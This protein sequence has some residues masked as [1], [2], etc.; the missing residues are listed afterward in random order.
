MKCWNWIYSSCT[1]GLE[2]SLNVTLDTVGRRTGRCFTI[3]AEAWLF[4]QLKCQPV[5]ISPEFL[6]HLL[7]VKWNPTSVSTREL[8]I[9]VGG[10]ASLENALWHKSH[11]KITLP[12]PYELYLSWSWTKAYSHAFIRFPIPYVIMYSPSPPILY[13][14][15]N[16]HYKS[17]R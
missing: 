17:L 5:R 6:R 1:G 12:K 15:Y 8:V 14:N 7:S 4:I 13:P 11:T 3:S 10:P 16:I 9:I 2:Q